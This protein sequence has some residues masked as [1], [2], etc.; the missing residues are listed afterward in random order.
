MNGGPSAMKRQS[1]IQIMFAVT[2][3]ALAFAASAGASGQHIGGHDPQALAADPRQATEAIAPVLSGLGAAT[4]GWGRL[5]NSIRTDR[6][7]R[8]QKITI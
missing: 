6:A 1:N 7:P 8:N 2:I 3:T 5:C 4:G